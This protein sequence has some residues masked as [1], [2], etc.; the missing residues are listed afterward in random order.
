[1]VTTTEQA[2][3]GSEEAV[4]D[5]SAEGATVASGE[6]TET[7]APAATLVDSEPEGLVTDISGESEQQSDTTS[8]DPPADRQTIDE[9]EIQTEIDQLRAATQADMERYGTE[10]DYYTRHSNN[11][12]QRQVQISRLQSILLKEEEEQEYYDLVDSLDSAHGEEYETLAKTIAAKHDDITSDHPRHFEYQRN[13]D[14]TSATEESRYGVVVRLLNDEAH[15]SAES[16]NNTEKVIGFDGDGIAYV[17]S[18]GNGP[19]RPLNDIR[20]GATNRNIIGWAP[21]GTAILANFAKGQFDVASKSELRARQAQRENREAANEVGMRALQHFRETGETQWQGAGGSTQQAA[22]DKASEEADIQQR[23][24]DYDA[25]RAAQADVNAAAVAAALEQAQSKPEPTPEPVVPAAPATQSTGVFEQDIESGNVQSVRL[26]VAAAEEAQKEAERQRIAGAARL[27]AAQDAQDE[28]GYDENESSDLGREFTEADKKAAE[29]LD[30][31]IIYHDDAAQR[32]AARLKAAQDAQ[33]EQGYDENESSDLGREFTEA[34]KKAAEGLDVD[35]IY[36][37]DAAQRTAARLKAAQ[38]AQDEQGY[39][40]NESSDLGREFTEADKKAAEGLD[41]DIIYHDDE[42]L[43]LDNLSYDDRADD[44]VYDLPALFAAGDERI[45][46]KKAIIEAQNQEDGGFFDRLGGQ[47]RDIKSEIVTGGDAITPTFNKDEVESRGYADIDH[48]DAMAFIGDESLADRN[49][50]MEE[51]LGL[52]RVEHEG[53]T[54]LMSAEEKKLFIELKS[55]A[56]DADY[57]REHGL[58]NIRSLSADNIPVPGMEIT[59]EE[60]DTSKLLHN[61]RDIKLSQKRMETAFEAMPKVKYHGERGSYNPRKTKNEHEANIEKALEGLSPAERETVLVEWEKEQLEPADVGKFIAES[62][63]FLGN[64]IKFHNMEQAAMK[65]DSPGGTEVLHSEIAPTTLDLF[66]SGA[67]LVPSVAFDAGLKLA[68]AG[69]K[70]SARFARLVKRSV[71]GQVDESMHTGSDTIRIPLTGPETFDIQK[72][73]VEQGTQGKPVDVVIGNKVY[74]YEPDPYGKL[75]AE[76]NPDTRLAVTAGDRV[77]LQDGGPVPV[78]VGDSGYAKDAF[79]QATFD[80][81]TAVKSYAEEAS[82]SGQV[83]EKPVLAYQPIDLFPDLA[84]SNVRYLTPEEKVA[85]L[86]LTD[87][88]IIAKQFT[89]AELDAMLNKPV[90]PGGAGIPNKIW[91]ASADDAAAPP[92]DVRIDPYDFVG[93]APKLHKGEFHA[94]EIELYTPS[95]ASNE[96]FISELEPLTQFTL[97]GSA[98]KGTHV[99]L[100]ASVSKPSYVR[101]IKGNFRTYFDERSGKQY[102]LYPT[103]DITSASDD[104]IANTVRRYDRTRPTAEPAPG[105]ADLSNGLS[106]GHPSSALDDAADY[107]DGAIDDIGAVSG[108]LSNGLSPGH[109]AS[110]LDDAAGYGDG[111]I[112]DIGAVSGDLSNGLSPGHPSSALDDAAGYGDGAIDDIG[113]VSG[114]LSNGLSPGHPASALDDAAGYGDGAIDDIGA[115]SGD[116]SNGLSPG[117]PASALDDAAGYGD[118]AIDD[119]GA[120]SGDLSNGL[121]PGHPSSALDDTSEIARLYRLSDDEL[122]TLANEGNDLAALT[123]KAKKSGRE[124]ETGIDNTRRPRPIDDSSGGVSPVS[125]VVIKPA[126]PDSRYDV[127]VDDYGDTFGYTERPVVV[128]PDDT[129]FVV[130]PD[131]G[132]RERPVVVPPD[133]TRFVVRPDDGRR[134]RPVVVPPDDTRFVVRPDDGRRERP[135]VVPPDDTRFVVRPDDGRRERPVVVPPDDTRFVVRP[136]DGRPKTTTVTDTTGERPDTTTVPDTES[137]LTTVPETESRITTVPETESRITTVPETESRITTVPETESRITTVPETESRITTVPETESRITTVPETESRITTVP[138]TESRITT[139]PE[140]ESRITTVPE[141]ETTTTTV[142]ETESRITTVPETETTTTT[143]PETESRITTVPETETTTT[144]VPETE[145][146][147]TTVPGGGTTPPDKTTRARQ[148]DDGGSRE[149]RQPDSNARYPARIQWFKDDQIHELDL[150]TNQLTSKF[151]LHDATPSHETVRVTQYTEAAPVERFV[152][153]GEVDVKVGANGISYVK[154][155]DLQADAQSNIPAVE[156]NL[157]MIEDTSLNV[158]LKPQAAIM[159]VNLADGLFTPQVAPQPKRRGSVKPSVRSNAKKVQPPARRRS[160]TGK[161][162]FLSRGEQRRI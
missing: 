87:P 9:T 103:G 137:R 77:K 70:P 26:S 153:L 52:E 27:K 157:D 132:R 127:G 133:D 159:D 30:V 140:T 54:Y 151:A 14:G 85:A 5:G 36:H 47:L 76:A 57:R 97:A 105:A 120:V 125:G 31:D 34:D 101:Q 8:A 45:R 58:R 114:D 28:Q 12:A 147:T 135:V 126:L 51:H 23:Q 67:D 61:E 33:D 60:F 16:R 42:Q 158:N 146:T 139:V 43:R 118:G 72:T 107:G 113:T 40:E 128:P 24:D 49:S 106:P 17:R 134:E 78:L 136:D 44:E 29:G 116:L 99:G 145:T 94:S 74:H 81:P 53:K 88:D 111:A 39:D 50:Q 117:H 156:L 143:V 119:I 7:T 11:V 150:H 80:S 92:P 59:D 13:D 144:T 73:I 63:P 68:A 86:R 124:I 48:D 149:D 56:A 10:Y 141:T 3:A 41:V 4:A 6:Q 91:K 1:M 110:A 75:L 123:L 79:E 142:P 69:L 95:P 152:E 115:V 2:V 102:G 98:L 148:D 138:E 71:R 93:K 121:S 20:D 62:A 155:S 89:P 130:R 22:T 108:D 104:V 37:D 64:A 122:E 109:P 15:V 38:D 162:P 32:T 25:Q 131:D 18:N 112:D 46:E 66:S 82:A 161:H 100:P 35:I 21:D 160:A 96:A 83:A 65:A 154:V 90:V 84:G 129:R 55:T 19:L